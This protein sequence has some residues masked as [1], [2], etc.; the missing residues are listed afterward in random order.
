MS[1][2]AER[3]KKAIATFYAE[4][5]RFGQNGEYERAIKAANKSE[6]LTS[7]TIWLK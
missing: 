1:E 3:D 2:K 7:K 6:Y 5:N 4:L